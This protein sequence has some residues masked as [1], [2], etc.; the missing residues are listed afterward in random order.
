MDFDPSPD[1]TDTRTSQEGSGIFVSWFDRDGNLVDLA[2]YAN[3]GYLSPVD[4]VVD[5]S[6]A[7]FLSGVFYGSMD[8]R[9]EA[10]YV[11]YSGPQEWGSFLMRM[12][13]R[14]GESGK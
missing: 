10:D 6:G 14:G 3:C 8:L 12:R 1:K 13:P 7:T 5:P 11:L 2:T 4:L 9:P